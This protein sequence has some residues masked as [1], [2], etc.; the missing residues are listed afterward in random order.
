M[1]HS[2]YGHYLIKTPHYQTRIHAHEEAKSVH[3]LCH[4]FATFQML[5]MTAAQLRSDLAKQG[6]VS[7]LPPSIRPC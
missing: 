4:P 7:K 5:Q 1:V 2:G 6:K 3:L